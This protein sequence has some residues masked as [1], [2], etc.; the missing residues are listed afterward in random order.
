MLEALKL[1][2]LNP[3]LQQT[4][5]L[6]ISDVV[7]MQSVHLNERTRVQDQ[8][9]GAAVAGTALGGPFLPLLGALRPIPPRIDVIAD[10]GVLGV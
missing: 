3:H 9:G 8:D 5:Q 10:R 2:D 7:S 1:F 6:P 4:L